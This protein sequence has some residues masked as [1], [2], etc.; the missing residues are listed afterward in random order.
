[1]ERSLTNRPARVTFTYDYHELLRGDLRPGCAV[2]VRY[3]PK[4]IVPDGEPYRFG[5][6][7]APIVAHASFRDGEPPVSKTLI[8]EAGVLEHPIVDVTGQGSMLTARFDVPENAD[9]VIL[10]FSY[11]SPQ[12]GMH[13][14]S[15]GGRNFRFSFP[16]R[17]LRVVAAD[18]VTNQQAHESTFSVEVACTTKTERVLVRARAVTHEEFKRELE[19]T[20]TDSGSDDPQG[21]PHWTLP[22]TPV[23]FQAIIEFKV[24]YWMRTVRYKDDNSGRYY[25]VPAPATRHVLPPPPKELAAAAQRWGEPPTSQSAG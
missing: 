13:Y 14:D 8:S 9:E 22:P 18:V 24:Y 2:L 17:E 11:A 25:L 15:D 20:R 19:L 1:M 5:D 4:R 6:P 7:N 16:S 21:W 12:G 23:P 3:D 10:W